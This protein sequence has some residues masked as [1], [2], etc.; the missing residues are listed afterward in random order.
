M[1]K[2]LLVLMLFSMPLSAQNKMRIAIM[3]FEAKDIPKADALKVSELIRNEIVNSAKFTVIERSQMGLILKEQGLQQSGC[4]DISCAVELGKVLSANKMLVGSV[5]KMG[6]K[7]IITGRIVDVEKGVAEFSEKEV[8]ADQGAE[9]LIAAV[10]NFT[11]KLILRIT[12]ERPATVAEFSS[13]F[14]KD[15]SILEGKIISDKGNVVKINLLSGKQMDIKRGDIIRILNTE[16]HKQKQYIYKTDG[17][18]IQ[19][20]IVDEDSTSYTYRKDYDSPDEV[21]VLKSDINTVAKKK[22][23]KVMTRRESMISRSSRW[24]LGLGISPV[25]DDL[26]DYYTNDTMLPPF[27]QSAVIDIFPYRWR[28]NDTDGVDA[29]FR[30]N[31]KL[32]KLNDISKLQYA[33]ITGERPSVFDSFEKNNYMVNL[34]W[35]LGARYITGFYYYGILWQ[36]Y[37]Y[38]AWQSFFSHEDFNLVNEG[39]N[40]KFTLSLFGVSAG[41]GVEAGFTDSISLFGEMNYGYCPG[42]LKIGKDRNIDGLNFLYGVSFRTVFA[43]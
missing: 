27:M 1:K 9:S 25:N 8:A 36:P 43:E 5:M 24:R 6:E 41:A 21:K 23:E 11:G 18:V 22:I 28:Y 39:G 29:M 2:I 19:A 30:I 15:G 13:V 42:D 34:G 16:E 3:D 33:L 37:A 12:G 35:S 7:V 14:I 31:V 10:N 26:S 20:F 38:L 4:V 17:K 32:R 40:G